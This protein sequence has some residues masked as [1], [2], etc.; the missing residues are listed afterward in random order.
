MKKLKLGIATAIAAISASAFTTLYDD[1][2]GHHVGRVGTDQWE[3]IILAE[4]NVTWTCNPG[5]TA[6]K[7][8]LKSNATAD[9]NGY[10]SDSEVNISY[11]N[12]Y[13]DNFSTDPLNEK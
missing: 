11:E 9:A 12:K 3:L 10:Y 5:G 8:T 4:E 1:L 6:C 7:G 13:Y 2:T